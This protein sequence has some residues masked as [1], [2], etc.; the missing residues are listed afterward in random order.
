MKDKTFN[1][2][3]AHTAVF[4]G[5]TWAYLDCC[6]ILNGGGDPRE[7]CIGDIVARATADLQ[8]AV[9]AT[10]PAN[11]G[12]AQLRINKLESTR[13]SLLQHNIDL[14]K[15]ID[16]LR[17]EFIEVIYEA[18]QLVLA[19]RTEPLDPYKKAQALTDLEKTLEKHVYAPE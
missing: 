19:L 11:S 9:P 4:A 14:A 2:P 8:P 5:V 13:N 3:A 16:K 7:T 10:T 15:Q 1:I 17:P 18:G 6:K 12:V